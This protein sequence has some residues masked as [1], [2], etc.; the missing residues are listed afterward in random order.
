MIELIRLDPTIK[1]DVRY[2][3]EKNFLGRQVYTTARVFLQPEPAGS[4]VAVH[5]Q[6]GERGLGLAIFDGYRPWS[7]TKL[8][9]ESVKPEH[10]IFVAD[11]ATGSNHNR[12]CAVDLSL[13]DRKTGELSL[14]LRHRLQL[15]GLRAS[16]NLAS[17]SLPPQ[18]PDRAVDS[19]VPNA[20]QQ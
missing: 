6:L 2:A 7:I 12:G 10:R 9:W 14:L 19:A 11:P 3:T 20:N 17:Q 8:F 15:Q 16:S 18:S 1:L 4:V 13:F 5:R